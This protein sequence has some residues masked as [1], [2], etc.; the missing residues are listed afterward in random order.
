MYEM[1][2][3]RYKTNKLLIDSL[4]SIVSLGSKLGLD[5]HKDSLFVNKCERCYLEPPYSAIKKIL[6]IRVGVRV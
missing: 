5:W 3:K 4:Y 1:L 6:R 2:I